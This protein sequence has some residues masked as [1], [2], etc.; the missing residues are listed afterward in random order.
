MPCL[1]PAATAVTQEVGLEQ[2]LDQRYPCPTPGQQTDHTLGIGSH[3][4][5]GE[6]KAQRG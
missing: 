3:F 2:G 4:P 1:L 6:P 5:K